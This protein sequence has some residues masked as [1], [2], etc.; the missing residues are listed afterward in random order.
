MAGLQALPSAPQALG[1][2]KLVLAT[3]EHEAGSPPTESTVLQEGATLSPGPGAPTRS[4][5]GLLDQA[6]SVPLSA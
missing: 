1:S 4:S 3:D 2:A 5:Q 6:L